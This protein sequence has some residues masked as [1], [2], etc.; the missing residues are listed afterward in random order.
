VKILRD[1]FEL[2]KAAAKE[3]E[4]PLLLVGDR[5]LIT[6]VMV[7]GSIGLSE[8]TVITVGMHRY[9]KV[10]TKY[11]PFPNQGCNL[12]EEGGRW[13]FVDECGDEIIVG[14][15]ESPEEKN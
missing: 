2:A 4:V 9:G 1:T 3:S 5:G 7:V 10:I 13:R 8:R 15:I 14:I 11:D 12:V 6:D